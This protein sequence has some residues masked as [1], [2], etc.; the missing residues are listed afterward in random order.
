M[1]AY[2]T[3]YCAYSCECANGP[4]YGLNLGSISEVEVN[5]FRSPVRKFCREQRM[6]WYSN[7]FIFRLL[8]SDSSSGQGPPRHTQPR[9]DECYLQ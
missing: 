3:D 8:Y 6:P 4:M 1:P 2:F 5:P 7:A 9:N